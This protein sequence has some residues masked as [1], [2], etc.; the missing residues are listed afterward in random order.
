MS[1]RSIDQTASPAPGNRLTQLLSM[2]Q[3]QTA[4]HP[5]NLLDPSSQKECSRKH[6]YVVARDMAA[7]ERAVRKE[8]GETVEDPIRLYWEHVIA[9]VRVERL[10]MVCLRKE[11]TAGL[12]C[13]GH[14]AHVAQPDAPGHAP[15]A[16]DGAPKR[17]MD[18]EPELDSELYEHQNHGKRQ[19]IDFDQFVV[20]E[21]AVP[22]GH[23]AKL[24]AP[25]F[26]PVLRMMSAMLSR[27]VLDMIGTATLPDE[28]RRFVRYH[29]LDK[30]KHAADGSIV[31]SQESEFFELW[32]V[33]LGLKQRN[34]L[35]LIA[36]QTRAP[37]LHGLLMTGDKFLSNP[38]N[39]PLT[40]EVVAK[41]REFLT[42]Y[43]AARGLP[44]DQAMIE[45]YDENWE[46]LKDYFSG[47]VSQEYVS[48]T[49]Y[50]HLLT[51]RKN[52][53]SSGTNEVLVVCTGMLEGDIVIEGIVACPFFSATH[54]G[55]GKMVV[56]YMEKRVQNEKVKLRVSPHSQSPEWRAF[57]ASKPF[58]RDHHGRKLGPYGYR[59]SDSSDDE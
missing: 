9:R 3:A 32:R 26:A 4:V 13:C 45:D 53:L 44:A 30:A 10:N 1:L 20:M 51:V 8:K 59:G 41:L 56:M 7:R 33:F 17:K 54:R 46:I 57:L 11:V 19:Q 6:V 43:L 15:P 39:T 2:P 16:Q 23:N 27:V 58:T 29:S 52:N 37:D 31:V 49:T 22:E 48:N 38:F 47:S 25:G 42:T 40:T 35:G 36:D 5:P 55:L 28:G 12:S 14:S 34:L 21:T 50:T 18:M 24:R